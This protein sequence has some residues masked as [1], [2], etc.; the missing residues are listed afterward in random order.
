MPG[1]ISFKWLSL[2]S[3]PGFIEG[4]KAFSKWL[5][6]P[7]VFQKLCASCIDQRSLTAGDPRPA[8]SSASVIASLLSSSSGLVS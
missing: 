5:V 7:L 1:R 8:E 2:P 6:L 3:C 4:V